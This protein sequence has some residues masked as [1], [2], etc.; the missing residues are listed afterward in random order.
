MDEWCT[1][2][3]RNLGVGNLKQMD[4]NGMVEI[5]FRAGQDPQSCYNNNNN[6]INVPCSLPIFVSISL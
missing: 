3:L 6:N 2:N 4:K 1:K 5:D